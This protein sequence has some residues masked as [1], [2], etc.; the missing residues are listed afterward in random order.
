MQHFREKFLNFIASFDSL[1]L[2]F[3]KLNWM[4][5]K[6][7]MTSQTLIYVFQFNSVSAMEELKLGCGYQDLMQL[8]VSISES[9][10]E[11]SLIPTSLARLYCEH[12]TFSAKVGRGRVV[13]CVILPDG[14]PYQGGPGDQ[15]PPDQHPAAALHANHA[16]PQ[17]LHTHLSN[18]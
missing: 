16:G 2:P 12:T 11:K 1:N 5:K 10:L 6:N 8:E 18:W 15:G 17:G 13:S 3:K 14:A 7:L 9:I 4:I